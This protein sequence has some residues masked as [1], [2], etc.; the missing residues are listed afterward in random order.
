MVR[1]DGA[2]GYF[3]FVLTLCVSLGYGGFAIAVS[4]FWSSAI[5]TYMQ[6]YGVVLAVPNIRG[7]S[8]FGEEWHL[9]GTRENK[10]RRIFALS[11]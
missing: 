9:A 2:I 4:P 7:G 11:T 6:K 5:M 1:C 3:V 10:V 8:E